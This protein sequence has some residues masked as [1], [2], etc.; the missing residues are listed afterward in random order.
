[1]PA[2]TNER[3]GSEI[4]GNIIDALHEKRIKMFFVTHLYEFAHAYAGAK[5]K[6]VVFL[7]AEREEDG[8]RTFKLLLGEPLRTS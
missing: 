3:G 8:A 4:A 1:L 2:A 6:G 7:R 5:A